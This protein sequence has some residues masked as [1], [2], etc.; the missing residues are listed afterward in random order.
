M[1]PINRNELKGKHIR[2]LDND[3]KIRI[4]KVRKIGCKWLTVKVPL[5]K[6]GRRV[7]Q[8]RVI[9]Q[10]MRKTGVKPIKW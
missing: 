9:G 2:Y 7:K 10:Q 8:E 3:G 1:T 4:G 6:K 5:Q